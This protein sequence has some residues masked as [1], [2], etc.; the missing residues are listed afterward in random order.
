MN[1]SVE[2]KSSCNY[3]IPKLGDHLGA[4]RTSQLNS[5]L[6]SGADASLDAFHGRIAKALCRTRRPSERRSQPGCERSGPMRLLS[7]DEKRPASVGSN[8]TSPRLRHS[9]V[10][11]LAKLA[12][13]LSLT[14]RPCHSIAL[15]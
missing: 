13:A 7:K 2:Q 15:L 9:S 1:G 12:K 10:F 11:G 3:T 14:I 4:Q 6:V 8:C 5:Q